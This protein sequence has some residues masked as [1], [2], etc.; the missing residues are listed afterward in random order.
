MPLVTGHRLD[1]TIHPTTLLSTHPVL[2]P[3]FDYRHIVQHPLLS[4]QTT[5]CGSHWVDFGAVAFGKSIVADLRGLHD[6]KS[7]P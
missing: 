1:L 3:Q 7:V 5:D 6:Y 2:N 4:S